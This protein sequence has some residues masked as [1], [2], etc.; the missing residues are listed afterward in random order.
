LILM[1]GL[2]FED[3]LPRLLAA[4][5]T[6][7]PVITLSDGIKTLSDSNQQVDPH[8][9]HSVSN[10][11]LYVENIVNAFCEVNPDNFP[12]YQANATSYHQQLIQLDKEIQQAVKA[13]PTHKRTVVIRH[14]AFQYFEDRYGLHFFALEGSAAQAETSARRLANAIKQ[15]QQGSASAIFAESF[16]DSRLITQVSKESG[17]AISGT[18]YSDTLSRES[19]EAQSYIASMKHNTGL[20]KQA[21]TQP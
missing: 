12:L 19:G 17:V 5:E 10:V 21:L 1:N 20:L 14:Q 18:L 8:A 2:Q 3:F 9:W 15:L 16:H 13:I 11:L 7:A 6:P 4:S